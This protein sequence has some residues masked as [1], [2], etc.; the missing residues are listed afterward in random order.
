MA[1]SYNSE[2]ILPFHFFSHCVLVTWLICLCQDFSLSDE[3]FS[4]PA[5]RAS[6]VTVAWSG[7]QWYL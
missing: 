2:G 6:L 5:L 3:N 4:G 7:G 1:E